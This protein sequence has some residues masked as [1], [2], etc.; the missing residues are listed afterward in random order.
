MSDPECMILDQF[1]KIQTDVDSVLE[2][3]GPIDYQ[4]M[5]DTVCKIERRC[6]VIK[7]RAE[8]AMYSDA[9]TV[10]CDK[11]LKREIGSDFV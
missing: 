5:F 8:Y 11:S 4:A 1:S 10:R 2:G 9:D 6:K 3:C 7:N